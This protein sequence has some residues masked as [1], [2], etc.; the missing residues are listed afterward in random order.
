MGFLFFLVV[1]PIALLMRLMG[2]R[3]LETAFDTDAT[4]YWVK[5][6]PPGPAPE[7]MK[8]QF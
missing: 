8:Q 3:P 7:T 2:K 6:G 4:S 1:T 5:R